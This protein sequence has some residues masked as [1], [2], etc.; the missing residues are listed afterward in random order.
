MPKSPAVRKVLHMIET[1]G[2]G[3]AENML[4]NNV[5]TLRRKGIDGDVLLI[6]DGW[7]R[8][9]L[10]SLDITCHLVP[11]E[12]FLSPRWLST[13]RAIIKQGKYDALHAHEFAM[14][15]HAAVL[16]P[17][18]GI[19]AIATVHGKNYYAERPA[20]RLL[21][22]WLSRI[23]QFVAVSD[24]IKSFLCDRVGLSADRVAVIANGI[25]IDKFRSDEDIR[26]SVRAEFG[27]GQDELLV[28]AV[29][30]LYPVKGHIYLV[31]AAAEILAASPRAR[32]VIAG[33]GGEQERLQ[34][35]I[36]R[37]QLGDRFRLLGF[38][39]DVERLLQGFDIFAMPSLSEGMPLSIL[40]AMAARRVVVASAVGGIPE[41]IRTGENG[42]LVPAMDAGLLA[43]TL[44]EIINEPA[45]RERIAAQAF[46]EVSAKY[47]QDPCT[48]A[49]IRLYN[50]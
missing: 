48:D 30:N 20:R 47:S 39:D 17:I 40:E 13:V 14:N 22:R 43:K 5:L 8:R 49:Y 25:D 46:A 16:S 18:C 12:R 15:C 2:P 19:P 41:F 44:L 45:L 33:R 24:D 37:L 10:Q 42:L 31:Q 6:K 21:Y 26:A 3:G 35:E 50:R 7:L 4:I 32:F 29:G 27:I 23:A 1:S 9:R 11:L 28:G 38:R 36:E 34:Q